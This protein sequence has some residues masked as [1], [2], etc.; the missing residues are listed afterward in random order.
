MAVTGGVWTGSW[1]R[2]GRIATPGGI[3][4]AGRGKLGAPAFASTPLTMLGAVVL[5]LLQIS[6]C[7]H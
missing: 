2:R 5:L 1:R 6:A 3:L 7:E 4:A